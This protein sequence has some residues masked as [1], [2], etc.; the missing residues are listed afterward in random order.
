M[1]ILTELQ[2]QMGSV[3]DIRETNRP[4]PFFNHLSA[5][6]EG[7]RALGWITVEFKPADYIE[8]AYGSS[9]FFGN[10]VLKEYKERYDITQVLSC[11]SLY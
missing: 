10:R 5:V 6:S 11:C 9:Q 3:G 7:I 2:R 4:S 1:E 8:E